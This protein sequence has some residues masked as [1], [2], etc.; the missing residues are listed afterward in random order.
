MDLAKHIRPLSGEADWPLWKRKIRDLLDYHEGTLD[1]IDRKLVKPELDPNCEDKEEIEEYFRDATLYRKANSYAKSMISSAVTDSVYQKIMDKETAADAWDALKKL[2]EASSKDQLFKI[3][4]DFFAFGWSAE[5]DVSTHTAKLASLFSELNN[6][7][8]AKKEN[9]LPELLLVCKSLQVLPPQFENFRSSWMLLSKDSEKSFDELVSQLCMYERN[10]KP[11]SDFEKTEA[12]H[13]GRGNPKAQGRK[14]QASDIC[15]YCKKQGHWVRHCQK[16]IRDGRPKKVVNEVESKVEDNVALMISN[17]EI[18]EASTA[19]DRWWF[20]NGA[21]Q[22]VTH[23]SNYFVDFKPFQEHKC[24]I[25]AGGALL[26]AI[27]TGTILVRTHSGDELTLRDVWYVPQV[28]KNLFSVLAAHDRHPKSKF[29]SDAGSCHFEVEG[30]P[31]VRGHREVRGSLYQADFIPYTQNAAK[32][33]VNVNEKG[34]SWLQLYHERW[35]HQDKKHVRDLMRRELEIEV[36]LDRDLCEPCVYG[37]QHRLK[38][39]TRRASTAPGELMSADI[40]GPFDDS[41]NKYKFVVIFKDNYT[42]F[43]YGFFLRKKSEVP[44]VLKSVIAHAT[45]LGHKILEFLSDNGGEFDSSHVRSILSNAG[46]SQ[47]LT[48]PYTPEQNGGSERE[49]RTIIEMART[50]KYANPEVEFPAALWKEFVST[51]IYVLNRTGKSSVE[52][53]TPHE[54]WMRKRPRIKHLRVIGCLCFVHIPDQKRRK[55]DKKAKKGYLVGYDGDERYRVYIKENHEVVVS[56]DVQFHEKLSECRARVKLPFRDCP[57]E[58]SG[59]LQKEQKEGLKKDEQAPTEEEE[60]TQREQTQSQDT[61]KEILPKEESGGEDHED[62][63]EVENPEEVKD[64]STGSSWGSFLNRIR[65]PPSYLKDYVTDVELYSM[66]T[67]PQTYAEAV[68]SEKSV[69][70]R[71]AMDSEIA[72]LK[73]NQTWEVVDLPKGAKALPCKWVYRVKETQDGRIDRYK[74][75]VVIKG[76][77]QRYG[78]DYRE[79]FSPVAKLATIRSILSVAANENLHLSQFDVTTAFLYGH[80]EEEIYMK[81]PEGY[82][83]GEE[84]VC[85]LQRSLYGL[86]Q[87]PR[88]WNHRFIAYIKK[89]GLS[90]STADPCLFVRESREEKLLLAVYVDD[91]LLAAS[92][93][94]TLQECLEGLKLQFKITAKD[95]SFFLGIEIIKDASGIRITQAAQARKILE[96]FNFIGCKPV[97]TPMLRSSEAGKVGKEDGLAGRKPVSSEDFPY[98]QAVGALMYLMLGTRPDLAFSIGVLSRSLENPSSENVMMLKRVL[99]YIAG[100]MN[101]GIF[102]GRSGEKSILEAYSDSDYGGC[103]ETG[104]STSGVVA[105]FAGGAISWMSQRQSSVATS[106]TEAEIIAAS[107]AA[108]EVVWLERLFREITELSDIPTIYVDNSAAVRLSQNPEFHRRTKHIMIR[109]FYVREKVTE[110]EVRVQQISTENQAADIFTKPLLKVR[111]FFLCR[112]LGMC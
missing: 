83:E 30:R 27:G 22:H 23:S 73:E 6:G 49:N 82:E 19:S 69:E 90:V 43:K 107:E 109:H 1:V 46:I 105:K 93:E 110:K 26:R 85:K 10:F 71:K 3:C 7:L 80:L 68:Q 55:M 29:V 35:G 11:A 14:A 4:T 48:S 70:W 9:P 13:I 77:S 64:Q 58:T 25:A 56:R 98:R 33:E 41:F 51:A 103:L 40:V 57:E 8:K 37:K 21:T 53:A 74:A 81:Q 67:A 62:C 2:Y 101:F 60:R 54:L 84:K 24:V 31:V 36:K 61:G 91:G 65:K 50:F 66:F 18:L 42:K 78:I 87:A 52:G 95:A 97:G 12:F 104:R 16:W 44:E 111:H 92:K 112:L 59:A 108:R 96:K 72:S 89:L 17:V 20:D 47:R 34:S 102:Y 38:F 106:T 63:E 28:S 94:S 76:F 88:C 32:S 79:T 100:T 86:K 15:N 45:A 99:R 39:G 5:A 75:R